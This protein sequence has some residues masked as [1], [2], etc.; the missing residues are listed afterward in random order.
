MKTKKKKGSIWRKPVKKTESMDEFMKRRGK[1]T[2][3]VILRET[4][5]N[6]RMAAGSHQLMGLQTE[7][8]TVHKKTRKKLQKTAQK[9]KRRRR[10][11][12]PK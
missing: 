7:I 4:N 12:E 9:I 8:G 5:P 6:P 11:D 2:G 10:G 3:K 1:E